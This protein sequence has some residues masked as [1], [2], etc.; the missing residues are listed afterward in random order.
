MMTEMNEIEPI[1]APAAAAAASVSTVPSIDLIEKN[2]QDVNQLQEILRDNV[3]KVVDRG[4]QLD[5]LNESCESLQIEAN[6]FR[7]NTAR[8]KRHFGC[9]NKKWTIVVILLVVL[10][11][12]G[13]V[14]V[15]VTFVITKFV[16]VN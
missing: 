7:A 14:G 16:L 13:I 2:Q 3:S 9:K 5:Q 12:L 8:V 4:C 11:L 10:I 1:P 6:Q 15:A